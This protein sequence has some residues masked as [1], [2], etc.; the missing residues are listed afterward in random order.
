LNFLAKIL[1]SLFLL[2]GLVEGRLIAAERE[3][4]GV[5]VGGGPNIRMIFNQALK[6]SKRAVNSDWTKYLSENSSCHE[7]DK[8]WLNTHKS[9]LKNIFAPLRVKDI[10][11]FKSNEVISTTGE[12]LVLQGNDLILAN[13]KCRETVTDSSVASTVILKT[14]FDSEKLENIKP[15]SN[16]GVL[17]CLNSVVGGFVFSEEIRE[18]I[19]VNSV[20]SAQE[21]IDVETHSSLQQKLEVSRKLSVFALR[22]MEKYQLNTQFNPT[23][24][25]WM[26]QR[27]DGQLQSE[28]LANDIEATIYDIKATEPSQKSCAWTKYD[29]VSKIQFV[30]DRCDGEINSI[31]KAIQTVVHE[32]THHSPMSVTD[33]ETADAIGYFVAR[34]L[35][36]EFQNGVLAN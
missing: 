2:V 16:A 12:C 7:D 23:V 33:E 35:I 5:G 8:N 6:A 22:N 24:M 30:E 4:K 36:P 13:K 27:I 9:T 31:F 29:S 32:S 11:I 20:V 14:I 18:I 17:K 28:L 26:T 25:L 21:L 10:N 15:S 1:V 34:L 19:D 3:G